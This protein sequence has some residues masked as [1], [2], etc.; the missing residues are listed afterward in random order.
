MIFSFICFLLLVLIFLNIIYYNIFLILLF[1]YELIIFYFFLIIYFTYCFL[2]IYKNIIKSK[3]YYK[4]TNMY[5]SIKYDRCH[6]YIYN[7]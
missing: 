5:K 2:Y 4:N 7:E 1:L 3:M 6:F